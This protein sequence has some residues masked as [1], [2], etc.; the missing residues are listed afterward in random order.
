MSAL[1]K[2]VISHNIS[3]FLENNLLVFFFNYNHMST[4]EWRVLKN[5]F[6]KI[7]KVN[8]VNTLVAKNKIG[9]KIIKKNSENDSFSH[10]QIEDLLQVDP[11]DRSKSLTKGQDTVTDKSPICKPKVMLEGSVSRDVRDVKDV[12]Y[13]S[14]MKHRFQHSLRECQ[15]SGLCEMSQKVTPN[16]ITMFTGKTEKRVCN[17]NTLYSPN[18]ENGFENIYTLFQGPTFLIGI[19]VP[20]QSKEVLHT[21]KKEKKLIF[22]G[23]FYQKKQITHL[24]LDYLLKLEKG[25]NAY[26]INTL[27]YLLYL[28]P[29]TTQSV[30]LYYLLKCYKE[31]KS[32]EN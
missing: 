20:E 9:N 10:R 15:M 2:K 25:I 29:L 18:T 7:G 3:S 14:K 16:I 27:Q 1:K 12:S 5:Q 23:G 8:T 24:D 30:N 31:K 13:K 26:L 17:D 11:Q 6:S 22:V 4:E 19:N 21:I 32:L 28:A